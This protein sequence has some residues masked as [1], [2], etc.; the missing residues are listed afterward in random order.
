MPVFLVASYR[1]NF[2]P[3][4]FLLKP[5]LTVAV[6]INYLSIDLDAY[7]KW[8]FFGISRIVN[9]GFHELGP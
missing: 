8:R 2:V 9:D 6:Y 7:L 3:T 5:K 4:Y 1:V